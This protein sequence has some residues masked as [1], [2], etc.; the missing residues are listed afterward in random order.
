MDD[1][2]CSRKK[3]KTTKSVD[4]NCGQKIEDYEVG[5][6]FFEVYRYLAEP[7]DKADRPRST[8]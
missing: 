8:R 4:E 2:N 7:D 5:R 1:E 3:S 6:L